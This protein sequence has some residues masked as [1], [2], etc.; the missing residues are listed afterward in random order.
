[1][2]NRFFVEG[3]LLVAV[4]TDNIPHDLKIAA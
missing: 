1:L 2:C 3:K 4:Q